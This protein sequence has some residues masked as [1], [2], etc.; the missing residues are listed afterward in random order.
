M[1]RARFCVGL[2]SLE[3]RFEEVR[4]SVICAPRDL[5]LL[6]QEI[7]AMRNKLRAARPVP[8]GRFDVKHS[9]GGMVDI[10]FTVQ[11]LVLAHGQSHPDLRANVGN[12][13]LLQVAQDCGLLPAPLGHD[14]AQAYRTLRR[15][16][17]RARLNEEPTHVALGDALL[18]RQ[19]GLAVWS[20]VF[21]A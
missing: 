7:V 14:A 20:A 15:I 9:P 10:E 8:A 18:E 3:A 2:P 1:T 11:F 17:H 19:A 21:G 4:R 16:Q 12:I 5:A 6:A 13:A